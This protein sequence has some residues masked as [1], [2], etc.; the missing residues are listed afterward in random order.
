M[1]KKFL[2]YNQQ[3]KLLREHKNISC[4]NSAD[5]KILVRT[6]YFN[7]INGYKEPFISD[8]DANDNHVYLP[9]TDI[10][11]FYEVKTF[12]DELRILLLKYITQVE[13]EVR[14]LTGYKFDQCNKNGKISWY[15]TKAYNEEKKS[16][17]TH[18]CYFFCL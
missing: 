13:E 15:D 2:T 10:K 11:H 5:K 17:R 4:S 14:T 9:N 16:S 12:D 6:G 18:A 7:L 1:E 3:M 8:I